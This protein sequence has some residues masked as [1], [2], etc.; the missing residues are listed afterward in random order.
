MM[1]DAT[2]EF[3]SDRIGSRFISPQGIVSSAANRHSPPDQVR[4]QAS[5]ENALKSCRL[6]GSG[7]T[8]GQSY[9]F[10]LKQIGAVLTVRAGEAGGPFSHRPRI[11]AVAM[12]AR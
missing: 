12:S 6:F 3:R 10:V 11:P 8:A 2:S 1:R 4:G 7:H 9:L 5:V